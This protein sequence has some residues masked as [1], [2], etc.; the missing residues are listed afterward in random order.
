[1]LEHALADF[2]ARLLHPARPAL[3]E[4]DLFAHYAA[5]REQIEEQSIFSYREYMEMIDLLVFHKDYEVN[6]R[7]YWE[8]PTLIAQGRRYQGEKF[9]FVT[10]KLGQLLGAELYDAYLG[11]R[12]HKRFLRSL[13][14]RKLEK[15]GVAAA[16]YFAAAR[17]AR[18]PR[19][20][21]VV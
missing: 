3:R 17:R 7:R 19:R 16:A 15:S 14:F 2:G 21:V 20:R 5:T 6:M 13:Y 4:S 8:V 1:M 12:V 11:G 18:K 10:R 9:A